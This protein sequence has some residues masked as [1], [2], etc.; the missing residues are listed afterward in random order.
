LNE[1]Y[2]AASADIGE[3]HLWKENEFLTTLSSVF[4]MRG[5]PNV[6]RPTTWGFIVAD[7][8]GYIALFDKTPLSNHATNLPNLGVPSQ[9]LA[10]DYL[11]LVKIL[12]TGADHS[13]VNLALSPDETTLLCLY[14]NRRLTNFAFDL[15]CI[16]CFVTENCFH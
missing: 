14:S 1:N 10:E 3:I 6:M 2:I 15:S 11:K 16:L 5:I 7:R 8:S 12:F 4:P 9:K 13:I